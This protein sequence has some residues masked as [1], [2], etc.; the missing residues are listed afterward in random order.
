MSTCC[1]SL[2][3]YVVVLQLFMLPHLCLS[4]P[5]VI[6]TVEYYQDK[7]RQLSFDEV[8]SVAF[9]DN[10]IPSTVEVLNFGLLDA[11]LWVR[12]ETKGINPD[13][14][15]YMLKL[16][17][18]LLDHV[19][20]YYQTHGQW[21]EIVTGELHP[22]DTRYIP[23]RVFL[24][25]V[26]PHQGKSTVLYLKIE[27]AGTAALP[28]SIVSDLDL[29]FEGSETELYHG[30]FYGC[31]IIM[32]LYS[33]FL[34]ISLKEMSYL[35]YALL[36]LG[37]AFIQGMFAGHIQQKLVS[38]AYANEILLLAMLIVLEFTILFTMTF[39][40]IR[41]YSSI[42]YRFLKGYAIAIVLN[43]I[44]A[45]VFEYRINVAIASVSFL[46]VPFIL[47]FSCLFVLLKGN[48]AARFYIIA[49]TLHLIT[50]VMFTLRSLGLL[51]NFFDVELA[52]R[53]VSLIEIVMLS[54]ALGIVQK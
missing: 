53:S 43:I 36:V 2:L 21:Q 49:G 11:S 17:Y 1:L 29:R 14:G 28:M 35:F 32:I 20:Y 51:S 44:L 26:P 46:I 30:F 16:D 34:F 7:T 4:D 54:L 50:V 37:N 40:E 22:S 18:P 31:M 6:S 8:S 48:K 47:W 38:I 9:A 33:F 19:S 45:F 5:I 42:I 25:P 24:F 10:F 41:R 39:L 27:T 13:S 15:K 12:I 23:H 52:M 3:R